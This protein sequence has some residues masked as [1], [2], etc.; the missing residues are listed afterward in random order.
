MTA[1]EERLRFED[2]VAPTKIFCWSRILGA[3][4]P[5]QKKRTNILLSPKI[6]ITSK[7]LNKKWLLD[8][9]QNKSHPGILQSSQLCSE[10]H[11][12]QRFDEAKK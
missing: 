6:L 9:F 11:R 4:T 2:T 1:A 7:K 8:I 12:R 3:P 10:P 5:P